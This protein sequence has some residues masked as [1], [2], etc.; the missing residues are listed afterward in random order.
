MGCEGGIGKFVPRITDWHHEACRVMTNDGLEGR[1]FLSH[2]HT[3]NRFFFLLTTRYLILFGEK[4]EKRLLES[5]EYTE[6]RHGDVILSLQ[7]R[8]EKTCGQRAADVRL[9]VFY[10]S[11]GLVRVCEIGLYHMGKNN[12]NP[13]LVCENINSPVRT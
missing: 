5:P 10:L 9:F 7:K 6:M 1:N 8:H 4:R 2:P 11:L 12:G 13:D 3:N